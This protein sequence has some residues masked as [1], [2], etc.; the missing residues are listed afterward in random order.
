MQRVTR[1]YPL[2]LC[3]YPILFYFDHNHG[4][5]AIGELPIPLLIAL[6]L[7][8]G[9]WWLLGRLIKNPDKAALLVTF[10]WIWFFTYGHLVWFGDHQLS[11]PI[12]MFI[13]DQPVLSWAQGLLLGTLLLALVHKVSND[14]RTALAVIS[15]LLLLTTLGP[16]TW[17]EVSRAHRM[18]ATLDKTLTATRATSVTNPNDPDIYYIIID[19]YTRADVL[20]RY[21]HFDNREFI[22][23]LK[24]KGFY[25]AS[26]AHANYGQ[27]IL[28]LGSSLNI[29]YLN[30]I[31]GLDNPGMN[32]HTQLIHR[33]KNNQAM[34]ILRSRGYAV[35]C[36][37]EYWAT[38]FDQPDIPLT[39]GGETGAGEYIGPTSSFPAMILDLTPVGPL[40]S[41]WFMLQAKRQKEHVETGDLA[42][43]KDAWNSR[44]EFFTQLANVPHPSRP[45]FVFAHTL[46]VHA[47]L[48]MDRNGQLVNTDL[49]FVWEPGISEQGGNIQTLAEYEQRYVDQMEAINAM[50]EKAVDTILRKATRPTII[51]IQGDHGPSGFHS[52]TDGEGAGRREQ[53]SILNAYYFSKGKPQGIRSDISPVNTFRVIFNHYFHTDYA[54]LP[55]HS[56]YSTWDKPYKFIDCTELIYKAEHPKQEQQGFSR[57]RESHTPR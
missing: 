53:L 21:Y 55:D 14:A 43:Y 34:R 39:T 57:S 7:V 56:Y 37:T 17:F 50:T 42:K 6:V 31:P 33:L 32:D 52:L 19:T 48:F 54:I 46:G 29:C 26:N 8:G 47:P 24:R 36:M 49:P 5:F 15:L 1:Y 11:N 41:Q 51:I 9:M 4:Y 22:S 3:L 12:A 23:H 27:T 28:S 44:R 40:T 45:L 25:I 18:Q 38:M 10:W 2:L 30:E 16:I 13:R 35:A 20:K